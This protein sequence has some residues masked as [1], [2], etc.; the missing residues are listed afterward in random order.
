MSESNAPQPVLAC[1]VHGPPTSPSCRHA[2]RPRRCNAFKHAAYRALHIPT[3]GTSLPNSLPGQPSSSNERCMAAAAPVNLVATPWESHLSPGVSA[4]SHAPYMGAPT[5][6]LEAV[7]LP[8]SVTVRLYPSV[9]VA[10]CVLASSTSWLQ[11]QQSRIYCRVVTMQ[12]IGS[13]ETHHDRACMGDNQA[14]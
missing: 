6:P 8:A 12:G 9:Q 2:P 3:S 5:D 14:T 4:A 1:S 7:P 13:H 11:G 10:S